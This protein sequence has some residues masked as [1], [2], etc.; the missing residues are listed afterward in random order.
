MPL[1]LA[2]FTEA[3]DA[4]AN[5]DVN[6][7]SDDYLDLVNNHARL[8][9]PMSLY[10]A[11]AQSA[12]L[13]RVRIDS[14]SIRLVG[15]PFIRPIQA[16]LLPANDPNL[17]DLSRSPF[18]LQVGEEIAIQATAAPAMT[19]RFFALLW[20]ADRLTPVPVGDIYPIRFTSATA[21]VAD[22]WTTLAITLDQA[23]A[24]GEYALIGS[25]HQSTNAIAHRWIIPDK[26]WR[27]GALSVTA[28]GNRTHKLFYQ[29]G[30]GEWGRFLNTSLPQLQVLCDGA[31][32]A[33][34][35]WMYIV[36]IRTLAP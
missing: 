10:A 19:E 29:H 16:A 34:V 8:R 7:L 6:F 30:L 20:L 22:A 13:N 23:I 2:A 12:T 27:P 9:S 24:P 33:H 32:A 25:E 11:H 18:K 3:I 14:P 17:M 1:H 31:D 4:T 36:R 5:T 15:N 28:V 21:A 35:G 26:P